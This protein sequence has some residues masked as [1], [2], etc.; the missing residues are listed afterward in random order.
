MSSSKAAQL[1]LRVGV[2]FAFL[3]P[4]LN[5]IVN[6]NSWLGYFP[7]FLRG[8]VPDLVLL[9]SFGTVEVVIALWLLSN[10]NIFLPALAATV[11]LVT[12]VVLN[13]SQFEVVFRD[14][15][16][17]SAALALAVDAWQKESKV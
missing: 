3:Y 6:P 7:A 16:I 17:A 15:A 8:I 13:F 1:I 9:H 5:A 4:A 11:M 12:I 2:A 10:K 14:L